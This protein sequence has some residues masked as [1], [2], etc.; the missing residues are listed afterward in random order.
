MLKVELHC[1]CRGDP[2]DY[3][4]TYTAHELID[5]YAQ[6]KFD[7]V[8]L[9]LHDTL[10]WTNDL[11]KYAQKKGILLIPGMERTIEHTHVVLLN[12]SAK[13]YAQIQTFDDL[14]RIKKQ[15]DRMLV[16]APHP[17]HPLVHGLGKKLE[18]YHDLF[19]VVEWSWYYHPWCNP[20]KKAQKVAQQYGKP[21]V[22][23]G[24]V[25]FLHHAGKTYSLVDADKN[26]HDIIR[27]IK[28]GRVHVVSKPLTLS[29][30]LRFMFRVAW[31][32]TKRRFVTHSAKR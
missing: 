12:I 30:F 16:I 1:H 5:R 10:L 19:D 22:G 23:T 13:E 20:N 11:L 17:Y 28:K 21:I 14:R 3:F 27:A 8:A 15:N 29:E 31:I 6:L 32:E 18:Q 2:Q 25:H 4:I 24:D 7:V 26:V 9:T